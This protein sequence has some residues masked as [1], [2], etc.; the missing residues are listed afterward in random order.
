MVR[1][2]KVL[3]AE[4]PQKW[5]AGTGAT[6]LPVPVLS[7]KTVCKDRQAGRSQPW[8]QNRN[9]RRYGRRVA[10][11]CF[12]TMPHVHVCLMPCLALVPSLSC[13]QAFHAQ[14]I[15]RAAC[16]DQLSQTQKVVSGSAPIPAD[17]TEF[18]A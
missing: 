12:F 16:M 11:H 17:T 6:N 15:L 8:G 13:S 14:Q 18:S 4:Q 7:H 1:R 2:L 5:R 10:R 3:K 9:K